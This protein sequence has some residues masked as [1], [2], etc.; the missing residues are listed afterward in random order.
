MF[1]DASE[2][3]AATEIVQLL[4]RFTLAVETAAVFLGQYADE[5]SCA[6]FHDRLE[7]EGLTG[8]EGA[9][10]ATAEAVR[11]GEKSLRATLRPT[12]E[13][14][15][16]AETLALTVAALLPADQVALPWVRALVA[17]AHPEYGRDAGPGYPDPWI[18][19]H[20][21]LFS[22]RL[23][24][25]TSVIDTRKQPL[26][27]RMHRLLQEMMTLD[28]GEHAHVFERTLLDHI[29]DRARFLWDGW[30]QHDY[31]WE[32]AP[33]T[34]CA[35]RWLERDGDDGPWLAFTVAGPLQHLGNFAAAERLKY[36]ALK[37]I[38]P[39]NP[40]HV[41]FLNNQAVLLQHTNQLAEAEPLLR[42]VVTIWENSLGC[43]HHNVA[44]AFNNLAAL[45][46]ETNRN[47]IK[48]RCKSFP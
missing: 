19:L 4:G 8:L 7:A 17:Q 11:H 32:L 37:R 14:L 24:Q 23:W 43:S 45:L 18:N 42:Q 15:S 6:A 28:A 38:C 9:V 13:R 3:I 35:D 41:E 10:S 46:K 5:V 39:E 25:A 20:R 44:S 12:L 34:A 40:N 33:L 36:C 2:R 26:V 31:R 29:R 1:R 21:H 27:A 16:P 47:G 22:L 48:G 30:V